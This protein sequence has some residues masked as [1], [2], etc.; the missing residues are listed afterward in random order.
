M[1]QAEVISYTLTANKH[2]Y[3]GFSDRFNIS[4]R[5]MADRFNIMAI[6]RNDKCGIVVFAVG[7]SARRAVIPGAR[8]QRRR[9]KCINLL[10]GF[11]DKRQMQGRRFVIRLEQAK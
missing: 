1:R 9:V 8:T 6:R 10:P 11:C 7:A 4:V 2:R 3:N 5:R